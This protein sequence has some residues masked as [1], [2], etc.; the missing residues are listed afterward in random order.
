VKNGVPYVTLGQ[1]ELAP[2]QSVTLATTFSNPAK[3]VIAYTPQLI[4]VKY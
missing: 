1:A 3:A 4:N 2:G